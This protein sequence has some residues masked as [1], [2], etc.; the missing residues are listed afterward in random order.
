MIEYLHCK[1]TVIHIC[2]GSSGNYKLPKKL[3]DI[4]LT[5]CGLGCG[6]IGSLNDSKLFSDIATVLFEHMSGIGFSRVVISLHRPFLV[7]CHP[8]R[9]K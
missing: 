7:M 8:V 2:V 9:R 3:H 6:S 5:S 1:S 4:N